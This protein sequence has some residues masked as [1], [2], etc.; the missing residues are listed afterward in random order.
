V[1]RVITRALSEV[2][3]QLETVTSIVTVDRL[4]AILGHFR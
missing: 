4:A 1:A 3:E 2:V